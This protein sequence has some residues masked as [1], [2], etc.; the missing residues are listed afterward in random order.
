MPR[1]RTLT[2]LARIH[3]SSFQGSESN[4]TCRIK[5]LTLLCTLNVR[6]TSYLRTDILDYLFDV[7]CIFT[8]GKSEQRS[9]GALER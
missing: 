6:G 7:A 2:Y 1:V 5:I 4:L 3:I 9:F 8:I